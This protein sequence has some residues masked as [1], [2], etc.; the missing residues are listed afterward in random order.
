MKIAK[1]ECKRCNHITMYETKKSLNNLS[2]LSRKFN[3][4]IMCPKCYHSHNINDIVYF[5][6][7]EIKEQE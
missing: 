5:E 3:V 2:N 7:E 6:K 4:G 1:L